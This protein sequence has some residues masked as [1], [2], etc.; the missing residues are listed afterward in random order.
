MTR[1]RNAISTNTKLM[2]V[3]KAN[4]YGLGSVLISQLAEANNIDYLGVA[5]PQEGIELRENNI[6]T[7]ILVLMESV[8]HQYNHCISHKLTQ[9]IYTKAS[10]D[11]IQHLAKTHN[12]TIKI[13]IK[14]D[15]GMNRQG[16]KESPTD[17]IHYALSQPNLEV[18]GLYTHLSDSE[19]TTQIETEKQLALFNTI[20]EPFTH[21]I[22]LIHMA[23]SGGIFLNKHTHFSMVRSGFKSY[24]HIADLHSEVL[25]TKPLKK[26]DT[27]SYEN[28]YIAERDTTLALLPIGYADGYPLNTNHTLQVDIHGTL[29][30]VVGRVCMDMILIDIG[31]NTT[32]Q[33][34]DKALLL[35]SQKDHPLNINTLSQNTNIPPRVLLSRLGSRIQRVLH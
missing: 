6:S 7:P 23:N 4:A 10:L 13:H 25:L 14:V 22:P 28:T 21:K 16:V 33:R 31:P 18:E 19:N 20:A 8:T 2:V 30:P 12:T 15:T 35:S 24:E 32:I 17:F 26:G 27:V 11:A 5:T 3:V 34:G 9:T 1:I 29:Y